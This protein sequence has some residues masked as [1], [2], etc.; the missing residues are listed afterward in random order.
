MA[1]HCGTDPHVP[2]FTD[3]KLWKMSYPG[4]EHRFE[5]MLSVVMLI[6]CRGPTKWPLQVPWGEGSTHATSGWDGT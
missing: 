4:K 3:G 6:Q 1:F 5:N 2:F